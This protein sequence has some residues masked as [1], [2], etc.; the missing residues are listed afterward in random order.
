MDDM[1]C[2]TNWITDWNITSDG[3]NY[4]PVNSTCK[5]FRDRYVNSQGLCETLWGNSFL[6]SNDLSTDPN[7]RCLLPWFPPN[8][9]NPNDEVIQRLLLQDGAAKYHL[10][11]I[12][13]V[14]LSC[15]LSILI[16]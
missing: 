13:V 2:V 16:N 3:S 1:S 6:Y 7:R 11:T 9:T 15:L 10:V 12:S 4:C 8:Q 14:M 5:T